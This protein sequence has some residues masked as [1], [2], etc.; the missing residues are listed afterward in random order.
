MSS[1]LADDDRR[2][3]P[4]AK[5]AKIYDEKDDYDD[6]DDP[7]DSEDD[8]DDDESGDKDFVPGPNHGLVGV[9]GEEEEEEED[10]DDDDDD[11]DD[12]DFE[13]PT[14]PIVD[15]ATQRKRDQK[16][17]R[18]K[19]R[20]YEQRLLGMTSRTKKVYPSR[21]YKKLP[22]RSTDYQCLAPGCGRL[23]RSAGGAH[24]HHMRVH[25]NQ[26]QKQNNVKDKKCHLCGEAFASKGRLCWYAGV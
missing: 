6:D 23:F 20:R 17:R 4:P 19:Q 26:A 2:T 10:D 14:T 18:Q 7:V 11:D 22:G 1:Y 16:T 24:L 5:I 12:S 8:K 3:R 13:M 9:E 25:R 21:F 15:E